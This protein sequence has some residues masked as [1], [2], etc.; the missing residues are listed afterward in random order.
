MPLLKL[1]LLESPFRTT[2]T[3]RN[4]R[5][6]KLLEPLEPLELPEP[7]GSLELLESLESA[8]LLD[9][10]GMGCTRIS[11]LVWRNWPRKC[12]YDVSIFLLEGLYC[13]KYPPN[14]LGR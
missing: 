9:Q 3:P 8:G 7:L 13:Q 4:G 6:P 14:F 10:T 2:R 1:E 5:I 11:L 12:I